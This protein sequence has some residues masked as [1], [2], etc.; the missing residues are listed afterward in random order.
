MAEDAASLARL[1]ADEVAIEPDEAVGVALELCERMPECAPGPSGPLTPGKVWISRTGSI[2]LSAGTDTTVRGVGDLLEVLLFASRRHVSRKLPGPLVLVVARAIGTVDAPQFDSCAELSRA[3]ARFD[4][5]DRRQALK[6]LFARWS[7]RQVPVVAAAADVSGLADFAP[8]QRAVRPAAISPA[9]GILRP[10]EEAETPPVAARRRRPMPRALLVGTALVGLAVGALVA[11]AP[12]ALGRL[13]SGLPPLP[14]APTASKEV[15]RPE[16]SSPVASETPAATSSAAE[17]SAAPLGV[18]VPTTGRTADL[19]APPEPLVQPQSVEADAAY[20]PS[21]DATGSA[22]FFHADTPQGSAL[23]RAERGENGAVLHVATILEDGARN[24][25][26]QLS[27]T[28]E[29]VA[30]DSDRDGV[31]GVY[32]ARPDGTGVRRV[33]AEGYAAM[34][35]WSPDGRW[36]SLLRGEPDNA[37]VWNLWLLH[38]DSGELTRVTSHQYGQVWGGAWF[39]DGRRVAYSHENRLVVHD[40]SSGKSA[41]YESPREGRL[42]RTPA[43]SPDGRFVIFQVF[44]DGAW[45]LDL[46]DGS[47]QRVLDDPSA[48]E[49]AWSPDGRRVAFH[50]RRSGEWGLWVMGR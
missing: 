27:P 28:G 19:G 22:V 14:E 8:E 46:T 35:R 30:F 3:L 38:L 47:M 45:L 15:A 24:Y 5:S 11:F 33:S 20:S 42:L 4:V 49:F 13:E 44:R 31:R 18:Q 39:P 37:K 6:N 34:P 32:V 48:E 9:I 12:A 2:E 29:L 7:E 26:V 43:V 10:S 16:T 23:K 40:L 1:L 21:F 25:H 50:S 36:L 17:P 41:R